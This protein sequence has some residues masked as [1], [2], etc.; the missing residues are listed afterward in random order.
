MLSLEAMIMGLDTSKV[1]IIPRGNMHGFTRGYDYGIGYLQGYHHIRNLIGR[2]TKTTVVRVRLREN[3]DGLNPQSQKFYSRPMIS[4]LIPASKKPDI[5]GS[6][7]T[8]MFAVPEEYFGGVHRQFVAFLLVQKRF[9]SEVAVEFRDADGFLYPHSVVRVGI[10]EIP[11]LINHSHFNH[12]IHSVGYIMSTHRKQHSYF[13]RN[14]KSSSSTKASNPACTSILSELII[15]AG[16]RVAR[17]TDSRD[18]PVP[19]APRRITTFSFSRLG[20]K[21]LDLI[22]PE[23]MSSRDIDVLH[24]DTENTMILYSIANGAF[25]WITHDSLISKKV[26]EFFEDGGLGF[27]YGKL[28]VI[29]ENLHDRTPQQHCFLMKL[30]NE[31]V[32]IEIKNGTVVHGT[33]TDS[34]NL[35][36]LLV[37]ETPRVKPKKPTAGKPLGRD[38]GSGRGRGRGPSDEALAALD[39]YMI[40]VLTRDGNGS[41]RVG[42]LGHPTRPEK[43]G[44]VGIPDANGSNSWFHNCPFRI[45]LLN[46]TARDDDSEGQVTLSVSDGLPPITS[47]EKE[48][49]NG[50]L[51][52][53]LRDGLRLSWIV[54]N[55]KIKQAANLASWSPLGGQRHWPTGEDFVIRFGSVLPA[56]DILPCQVVECILIMKFRVVHT[57]G[58]GVE[59]TLKLT[60]LSMQLAN[61]EGAHVNGRNSLLIL[62]EAL[63]CRRSKNYSEVVESCH[64][65]SKVQSELKEEKMRNESRCIDYNFTGLKSKMIH[66]DFSKKSKKFLLDPFLGDLGFILVLCLFIGGFFYLDY[67]AVLNLGF[68]LF[69][70]GGTPSSPSE[71]SEAIDKAPSATVNVNGRLG[72]LDEGGDL[73]DIYDG[74]WVWDDNYP[75]YKSLDWPFVI[76]DYTFG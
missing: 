56:K 43:K 48:R 38:R 9:G 34:L 46:Y 58:N 36:T 60:E 49:K 47:L 1:P 61:M 45:D 6:E 2:T 24:I 30:N 57:E 21:K 29:V 75:L 26:S 42:F 69:G 28:M 51:W 65:Y 62:K 8:L 32:S 64:L 63:S 13:D 33:I 23:G 3:A 44:T 15:L 4:L 76:L 72:F 25:R 66:V 22:T 12:L 67:R 16:N 52:K 54:V 11:H 71:S 50:K 17:S 39:Y 14:R 73:C 37:E 20:Q 40:H 10:E 18:L 35:E 27:K 55:R 5:I 68:P 19:V 41:G 31:T 70:L 59:M 53:E 74:Q 7:G